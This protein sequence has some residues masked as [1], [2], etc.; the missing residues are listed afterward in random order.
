MSEYSYPDLPVLEDLPAFVKEVAAEKRVTNLLLS[1]LDFHVTD[2]AFAETESNWFKKVN[3]LE[4]IKDLFHYGYAADVPLSADEYREKIYPLIMEMHAKAGYWGVQVP[5]G[6][7]EFDSE[8]ILTERA[9]KLLK[10]QKEI[11]E[12]AGLHISA[13]GGMWVDDWTQCLKPHIQATNILGSKFLYGPLSAPF[14]YFAE[15]ASSGEASVEWVEQYIED[16]SKQLRE[17]IGPFAAQYDVTLCEEPL[18]RFERMPLRLKEVTELA[19]KA[20]IDNFKVMV[21]MCHEFADGE[22]PV[23]YR[24]YIM[25]LHQAKKLHGIHI[26]AVHRGKLYESWFNQQYFNDFFAPFNDVGYKGEISIETFDAMEP[27]VEAA[28]INRKKFKNPI[29]VMI[30][31]LVYS[32]EK[33]SKVPV[34]AEA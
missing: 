34:L 5:V 30:N 25:K 9:V 8:G 16:F 33:L 24:S 20:D 27:V 23:K 21:D 22:G 32:T 13:V 17:E 2:E 12:N 1:F 14:L 29:G 6:G 10:Q 28:K 3:L 19:I 31:Q 4:T 18:Q 15:N 11:I 26:S 7:V